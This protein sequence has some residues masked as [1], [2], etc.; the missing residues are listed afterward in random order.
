MLG[1]LDR[2]GSERF[3][4]EPCSRR[5]PGA[6]VFN[7]PWP[8]GA[9]I[10]AANNDFESVNKQRSL[11]QRGGWLICRNSRRTGFRDLSSGDAS[12]GNRP[13]DG[14]PRRGDRPQ[15]SSYKAPSAR[16]HFRQE[17]QVEKSSPATPPQKDRT[18]DAS[19]DNRPRDGQP[20]RG[21]R[22]QQSS[23]KAP[24]AR[25]H[26]RQEKQVE[27][28]SPAT[29]PQKDR[30]K[31]ASRDNRP[32]DG[33]PR[34]G[35]RPQQSSYKAPSARAHFRQE[36]QVEKSSPANQPPTQ[37]KLNH[38]ALFASFEIHEFHMA[39]NFKGKDDFSC[40]QI[41]RSVCSVLESNGIITPTAVQRMAIPLLQ[42]NRTGIIRAPTGSGKTWV[43]TA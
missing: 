9:A 26:F 25:A 43:S 33:Q 12:R 3:R 2:L 36:K 5:M 37:A 22:P 29:P 21:D 28:S 15:Q 39:D 10:D 19:R 30:T 40:L 20:R 8:R 18:K 38:E 32:R 42:N 13:R 41:D 16:A 23:Y 1:C 31:D 6:F 24:S 7:L 11:R 27:K 17:K 34:R 14:Q 35:D 4:T